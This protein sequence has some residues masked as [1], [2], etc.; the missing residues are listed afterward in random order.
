MDFKYY[1]SEQIK[2][3]PSIM[4]RDA[5]KLCYQAAFGAEHLLS[6]K[7]AA[8]RYLYTELERTVACDGELYECISEDFCRV[9]LAVWKERGLS[10]E[11]LFELFVASAAV[12]K[13]GKTAMQSY[14]DDV[15]K[16]A[17]DGAFGFSSDE[18]Q[19]FLK[20]YT[21]AGMPAVHH[22][23]AYREEERPAY[24]IVKRELLKEY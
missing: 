1:L 3:H 18:W 17:D 9:N 7:E 14:L 13:D 4:P 21:D 22:S 16:L 12:K 20:K 8:R 19:D 2:K 5:V 11:S 15:G 24:R 10:A 23:E 6:D